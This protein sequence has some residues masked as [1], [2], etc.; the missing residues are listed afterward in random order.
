MSTLVVKNL[1]DQ[2]HEQLKLR[3]QRNHRSVT[4]EVVSLIEASVN[5]RRP[6]KELPPPLKLKSGH[7]LTIEEIEVAI[8]DSRYAHINS[9][10]ELNRYMDKLRADRDEVAR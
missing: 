5:A 3:A 6:N 2:L 8:A 10:D 7:M 9:V 1:P 4:K